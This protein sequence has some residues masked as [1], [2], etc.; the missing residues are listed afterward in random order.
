[1]SS[2][3]RKIKRRTENQKPMIA[4]NKKHTVKSE[5]SDV[6][7]QVSISFYNENIFR[8]DNDFF[9]AYELF[10]YD[11]IDMS[12]FKGYKLDCI[13]FLEN[14]VENDGM[15]NDEL[16]R[17]KYTIKD[18]HIYTVI[19]NEKVDLINTGEFIID[20]YQVNTCW[21]YMFFTNLLTNEQYMYYGD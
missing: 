18:D 4:S 3:N 16:F 6:K 17:Q 20:N 15:L 8:S 12:E 5:F 21:S 9:K 10:F 7:Y 1:M 11:L 19:N 14:S 2:I 13:D